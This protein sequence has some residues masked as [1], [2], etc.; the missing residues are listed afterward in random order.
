M[1]LYARAEAG[2]AAGTEEKAGKDVL[3]AHPSLTDSP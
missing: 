3:A 2:L 1:L